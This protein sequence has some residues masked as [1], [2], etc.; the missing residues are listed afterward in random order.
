MPGKLGTSSNTV[1]PNGSS[2]SSA[3]QSSDKITSAN[4]SSSSNSGALTLNGSSS[5]FGA[6]ANGSKAYRIPWL[7]D[8]V[9]QWQ[10]EIKSSREFVEVRREVMYTFGPDHYCVADSESRSQQCH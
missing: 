10:H 6:N 5:S 3:G 4:G 7:S 8:A 1:A 9:Q 2:V